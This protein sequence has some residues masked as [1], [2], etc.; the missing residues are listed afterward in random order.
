MKKLVGIGTPVLDH[1]ATVDS[2]GEFDGDSAALTCT[3]YGNDA[4]PDLKTVKEN[5]ERI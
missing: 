3:Q 2:L 1:I 4:I 5:M